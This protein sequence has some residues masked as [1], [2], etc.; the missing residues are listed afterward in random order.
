MRRASI[1]WAAL[2]V[3]FGNAF[4]SSQKNAHSRYANGEWD[5]S[6]VRLQDQKL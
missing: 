6:G 5:L 1:E 3:T 4:K 2:C